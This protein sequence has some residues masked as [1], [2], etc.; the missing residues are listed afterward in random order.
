M[1][2]AEAI[3]AGRPLVTN[4]VV[5][6]LELLRPAC[7]AGATDDPPSHAAAIRSLVDDA[8]L[9]ERLRA[10]CPTAGAPFVDRSQGLTAVLERVVPL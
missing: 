10:A 9:W 5:P 3:L 7:V 4:P 6:A 2:A 1:T 8:A